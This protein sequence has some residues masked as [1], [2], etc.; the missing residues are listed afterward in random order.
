MQTYI[1]ILRGINV[2]GQKTIKM[3]ELKAMYEAMKFN[4]VVT[5]IQ[6]GNVI[7]DTATGANEKEVANK[8]EREILKKFGFEVPVII[9]SATEIK[10]VLQNNPLLRK[11]GIDIEKLHVTFLEEIP[12]KSKIDTMKI[13]N[14]GQDEFVIE[15]KEIY[16]H[17]P[18]GY[19][20]T[21]L[22]N[23]FFEKALKMKAT[24]RNWRTVNTLFDLAT[25]NKK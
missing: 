25:K 3:V 18:G 13:P 15:G 6:S 23:N 9:R 20:A 16:L 7:F 12:E 14:T 24:T 2:S 8:I 10:Q 4:N 22:N 5:Y 19:G 1:S 21:K 17:C 11:K